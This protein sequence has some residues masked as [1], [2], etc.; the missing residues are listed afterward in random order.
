MGLSRPPIDRL[1][2][3]VRETEDGCW[4]WTHYIEKSGYAKL[5]VDRRA[6]MAHRFSY[7]Y[8]V[9]PI[10]AGLEIDHLCRNRACVNPYHLEPV[11]T[12]ENL[13]RRLP[14]VPYQTLKTHCPE[15]HPYDDENTYTGSGGRVCLICKRENARKY[16]ERN[17]ELTI[18]RARQWRLDNL[19]RSRE[20]TR[21]AQRR[22]RIKKKGQAA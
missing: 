1:M 3:K 13:R 4:Q 8:H 17:R 9:A 12:A 19:E 2:E 7:E 15:G 16:Y 18:E 11:T 10:P 21:E 6:V 22:Q 20:L 14:W 5:W